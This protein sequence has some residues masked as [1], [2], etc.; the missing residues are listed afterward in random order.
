MSFIMKK[1]NSEN[2]RKIKLTLFNKIPFKINCV[3]KGDT[4]GP[5]SFFF[6]LYSTLFLIPKYNF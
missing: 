1:H 2:E 5:G 3:N 4:F 6:N